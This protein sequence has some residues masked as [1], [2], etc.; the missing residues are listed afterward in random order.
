VLPAERER[1]RGRPIEEAGDRA[2]R[3]WALSIEAME[4]FVRGESVT[5]M[6]E[7]VFGA[8]ALKLGSSG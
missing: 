1:V 7:C 5:R 4:R 6:H 8:L 3:E 2:G